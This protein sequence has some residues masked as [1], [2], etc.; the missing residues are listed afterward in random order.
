VPAQQPVTT[1]AD[2][3]QVTPRLSY[4]GVRLLATWLDQE[5]LFGTV[6]EQLMRGGQ[7]VNFNFPNH[8]VVAQMSG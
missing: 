6:V 3:V 1:N 7:H 2:V 5:G 4:V 8:F